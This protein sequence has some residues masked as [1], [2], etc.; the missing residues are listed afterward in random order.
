M[1]RMF[2]GTSFFGMRTGSRGR[3]KARRGFQSPSD[4]R[5]E[6]TIEP[7]V[8]ACESAPGE[9]RRR[10]LQSGEGQRFSK[11]FNGRSG[12]I[13]VKGGIRKFTK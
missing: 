1:S 2:G 7:G 9:L 3:H 6:E 11:M 12:L 10:T 13:P 4:E 5:P 8:S